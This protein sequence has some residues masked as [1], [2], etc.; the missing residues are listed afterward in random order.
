[1]NFRTALLLFLFFSGS[2]IGQNN[3]YLIDSI[4]E[5]KFYFTQPNWKHLLDSLYIDGQKVRL[6]ASVSIDGQYYDSVGIRY[7]GYSS[8]NITQIKNPFN[9]KLDYKIDDQEH[10]GFNKIKLS[11]VIHDP[12]F[13]RE[14]LSYQIARKYMPASQAN[15]VNLYINDTLWGLY[16]NVEAVNKDFLSNHY[17]SRN[18]S[19]FKCNPNSLNLFGENSNLSL[20]HGNDS[21]DYEDFYTLK[22]DFGW[23]KLFNLMDTLNNHPNFIN[24]ILNVDRTLWMHAFNYSIIN[25]DSYI[26]YAQNYYLYEDNV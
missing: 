21:S 14:A 17:D 2:V 10:Q 15:F 13:I 20:S 23:E 5:I 3:F 18:N 11:N 16:S 26:G 4:K 1:M 12:T 24:Q 19:L 7:K 9:I 8:V 22:S 6:T 25:I